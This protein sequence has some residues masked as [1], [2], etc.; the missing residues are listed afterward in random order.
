MAKK[1]HGIEELVDKEI[2]IP[3][4]LW[5]YEETMQGIPNLY[6]TLK[7]NLAKVILM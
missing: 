6:I 2:N 1:W 7:K 5:Q 3:K 4:D